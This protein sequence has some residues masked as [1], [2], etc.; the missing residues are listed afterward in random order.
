MARPRKPD[1]L[2]VVEGTFRPDRHGEPPSMQPADNPPTPM[3]K[4]TKRKQQIWDEQIKE[5]PWL[6]TFDSMMCTVFVELYAQFEKAPVGFPTSRV[7][8]LARIAN[9]LGLTALSKSRVKIP[10]GKRP[11]NENDLF[12]DD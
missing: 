5:V 12:F 10:E 3:R 2:H 1:H 7:N 4:L 8:A 9:D 6:T 11:P